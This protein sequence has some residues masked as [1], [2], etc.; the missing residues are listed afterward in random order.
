MLR[1][2][3]LPLAALL[4]SACSVQAMAERRVPEDVRAHA[5]EQIDRLVAGDL[6]FVRDAF[7]DDA[8]NPDLLAQI[9]RMRS[10]VPDGAEAS[11]D[12]VG[13]MGTTE[14]AY[15]DGRGAVR[16][17]TYNLAHELAFESGG[18]PSGYLL[19]QTAYTLD[20]D[21]ACCVLRSI[22]ATRSGASPMRE[23]QVSRARLF[24]IMALLLL[25]TSLATAAFLLIRVG[26]RK[27]RAASGMNR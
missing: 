2:L 9:E 26:G 19:V 7:P 25:V 15:D 6:Q 1:P 21:G 12:I 17:G 27:A 24:R 13:V 18:T 16:R 22:N 3:L 4:L 10:N 14:Q 23:G 8:D 20:A 5:D 11:R